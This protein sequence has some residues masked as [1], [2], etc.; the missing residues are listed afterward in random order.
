MGKYERY[1]GVVLGK[2][3]FSKDVPLCYYEISLQLYCMCTVNED[4]NL[5]R[6]KCVFA[7]KVAPYFILISLKH[8]AHANQI[9]KLEKLQAFP[10]T[11]TCY[12][13]STA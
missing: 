3:C 10:K 1:S 2:D 9:T 11:I 4:L 13:S 5:C 6:F 8:F 12:K 7:Y